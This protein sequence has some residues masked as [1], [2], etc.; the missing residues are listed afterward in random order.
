MELIICP[1]CGNVAEVVERFVLHSTDGPVELAQTCCL[2]R[3]R[4]TVEVRALRGAVVR[5][6]AEPQRWNP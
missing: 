4:F 1:E 3:H 2:Q 5:R 6:S